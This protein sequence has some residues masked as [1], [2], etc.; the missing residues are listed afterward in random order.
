[1]CGFCGL[2]LGVD[3]WSEMGSAPPAQEDPSSQGSRQRE[4]LH[5]IALLNRITSHYGVAVRDWAGTSW[6][7]SHAT[8]ETAVIDRLGDLWPTV[9]RLARRRC[10]PLSPALIAALESRAP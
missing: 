2:M 5:H 9:E 6:I 3:H 7:V 8:G 4:R 10:D 1:M